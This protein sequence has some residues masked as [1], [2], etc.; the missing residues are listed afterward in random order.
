MMVIEDNPT[1]KPVAS[2]IKNNSLTGQQVRV[3]ELDRQAEWQSLVF[4]SR[5]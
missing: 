3:E 1:I 5:N 2:E 4:V